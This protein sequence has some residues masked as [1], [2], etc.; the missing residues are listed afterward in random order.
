MLYAEINWGRWIVRCPVCM[1]AEEVVYGEKKFRCRD[2]YG[3]CGHVETISYPSERAEIEDAL[4]ERAKQ[5]RNWVPGESV[6]ALHAENIE[7]G[8]RRV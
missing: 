8:A 4:S 7:H 1:S 2:E 3:G 5:N 6:A